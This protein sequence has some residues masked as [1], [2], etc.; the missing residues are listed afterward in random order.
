[1]ILGCRASVIPDDGSVLHIGAGAFRGCIGLVTVTIPSCIESIGDWAFE[2]CSKLI[3]VYELSEHVKVSPGSIFD[4]TGLGGYAFDIHTDAEATSRLWTD[5][6]GFVFYEDGELAYLL[7]YAGSSAEVTL[8]VSC[9]G[10]SYE[11]YGYAF[12]ANRTL[13]RVVIPTGVVHIS[14]SAFER[15]TA[16]ESVTL[17][18]SIEGILS[19]T[20]YKCSSLTHVEIP[21]GVSYIDWGAFSDCKALTDVTIPSTVTL[22]T[23]DAFYNCDAL[24]RVTFAKTEGW[25]ITDFWEEMSEIELSAQELAD[26]VTA[27]EYLRDTYGSCDW[28]R[29]A[30]E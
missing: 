25:S 13:T 29:A 18:S 23:A 11:I 4:T 20:F 9:H 16:L 26:P 8:P 22:I 12:Y 21:E 6:D 1:L 15:C 3:E 17:P 7:D 24:A 14:E 2:G 10:K 28:E 27:A 30:E 5:P 19:W